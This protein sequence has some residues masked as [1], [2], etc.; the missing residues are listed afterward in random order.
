M[1]TPPPTSPSTTYSLASP[2]YLASDTDPPVT[3]N[4]R[5]QSFSRLERLNDWNDRAHRAGYS[6]EKLAA[7]CGCSV[8]QL[9]RFWRRRHGSSPKEWLAKLQMETARTMLREGKAVKCVALEV[10]FRSASHF[11]RAFRGRFGLSPR[12]AIVAPLAS[13]DDYVV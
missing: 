4:K 6:T 1:K 12:E 8:R 3:S 9:E 10:G 7:L 13:A 11:A 5:A 2:C